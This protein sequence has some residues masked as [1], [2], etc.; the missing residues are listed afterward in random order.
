MFT[1]QIILDEESTGGG[2]FTLQHPIYAVLALIFS[3]IFLNTRI[4]NLF[5][6]KIQIWCIPQGISFSHNANHV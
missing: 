4:S 2:S 5:P 6:I 3:C 1:L